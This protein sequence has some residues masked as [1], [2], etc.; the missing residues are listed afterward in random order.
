[1][2]LS[3][4]YLKIEEERRQ[5]EKDEKK[6]K[7]KKRKREKRAR[8]KHVDSGP[9]SEEDITPAHQVDIVTEEMPEVSRTH[10][11]LK[12]QATSIWNGLPTYHHWIRWKDI[13]W[14][15]PQTILALTSHPIPAHKPI[16]TTWLWCVFNSGGPLLDYDVFLITTQEKWFVCGTQ[17]GTLQGFR[18]IGESDWLFAQ[19]YLTNQKGPLCIIAKYSAL[20]FQFKK[21]SC[22]WKAWIGTG[23]LQKANKPCAL[24]VYVILFFFSLLCNCSLECLTQWWWWERSQRSSQ[25]FGYRPGQ[26]CFHEASSCPFGMSK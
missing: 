2:P 4:Q 24:K 22:L 17:M 12:L 21:A 14:T 15:F 16:L 19:Q 6:K 25:S 11:S 3:D 13:E 20:Q 9:E 26:V 1:M 7:E 23:T 5:K 10:T 18:K 8:G